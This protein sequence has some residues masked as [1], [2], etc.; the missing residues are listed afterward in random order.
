MVKASSTAPTLWL[1]C[2][3]YKVTQTAIPTEVDALL[4][5]FASVF[6][7]PAGL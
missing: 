1:N 3:C 4:R 5:Q 6:E 2:T 7:A